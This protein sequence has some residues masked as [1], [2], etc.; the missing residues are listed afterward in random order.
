MKSKDSFRSK[1]RNSGE[2][3]DPQ[4][5]IEK[6]CEQLRQALQRG[7]TKPIEHILTQSPEHLRDQVLEELVA[8]ETQLRSKRGEAPT[9]EE[10]AARFGDR[11][12]AAWRG[13]RHYD[14]AI[15]RPAELE[16]S[17]HELD[18][19][20]ARTTFGESQE[21][22]V[23]DR[24]GEYE[25]NDQ[26]GAGTFGRVFK[27]RHASTGELVAIKQL[28]SRW[29]QRPAI[30]EQF[31]AEAQRMMR[32]DH[33]GVVRVYQLVDSVDL[34]YFVQEY[35]EGGD[36]THQIRQGRLAPQ[37]ATELVIQI[38]DALAHIHSFK[39]Y[40]RDL[41]PANVLLDSQ[42]KAH[43]ADFGLALADSDRWDQSRRPT[44][45][46]LYMSPEQLHG[47]WH[48]LNPR[49]DIWSLGVIYY[50]LL[51]GERPFQ[52]KDFDELRR[53]I[54]SRVPPA[55]R[56][57]DQSIPQAINR[58]CMSCLEKQ[59]RLR[60]ASAA[61]LR[62]DLRRELD[63][64]GQPAETAR[65]SAAPSVDVY[66]TPKLR[67]FTAAQADIYLRLMP[68]SY[69]NPEE[70][71][72]LIDYW[73]QRI[74]NHDPDMSF[75][76][77]VLVGVS[78]CGKSS[79]LEA[80]LLPRLPDNVTAILIQGSESETEVQLRKSLQKAFPDA[81]P[82]SSSWS[83]PEWTHRLREGELLR[84]GQK[85]LLVLDQ[86][87]QWLHAHGAD[88]VSLLRD[89]LQQCD[90]P[91]L[92]AI[93]CVREGFHSSLM[94]FVD[95]LDV[96]LDVERNYVTAHR[97]D[98]GH[99]RFVL[100]QFGC[101]LGRL[102][103]KLTPEQEKF[104]ET[105]V[106]QLAQADQDGVRSVRLVVLALVMA[107]REWTVAELE[108]LGGLD[109]IG[110]QFLLDSFEGRTAPEQYRR[111]LPAAMRVLESLLPGEGLEIKDAQTYA[112]LLR[113][114][115]LPERE[116]GSLLE[117]LVRK[118]FL[119]TPV[120]PDI[121]PELDVQ[122][123]S[124]EQRYYQLT[125]D[126]LVPSVR[127]WI[128]F[129]EEQSPSGRARL[130]LRRLSGAWTADYENRRHLPSLPEYLQIRRHTEKNRWTDLQRRMMRV[131][132]RFYGVRF[133]LG[134]TGL[135]ALVAIGF[136]VRTNVAKQ[137]EATRIQGLVGGLVNAE[138]NQ[139]P[140]IAKELDA[141]PT[142][143]A[144]YLSSLL[145]GNPST[146]DVKRSQLHARLA[147]V[148]RDPS[149]V[150]PLKE[151]LLTGKLTYVMPIR[152]QL[153]PYAATLTEEFRVVLREENDPQ[154]R[155]RASLALADYVRE[156]DAAFWT[157]RDLQFVADQLVSANAVYQPQ[158]WE[159][160]APVDTRLVQ[161]LQQVFVDSGRPENERLAA[162]NAL[163]HFLPDDVTR[164]AELLTV[165]HA[166]P[167]PDHLRWF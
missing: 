133:S 126:F 20:D 158:L 162:A 109:G 160:L 135:V 28:K 27:A 36:L 9:W 23:P 154:R 65:P 34:P 146:P 70:L 92:Q 127:Q 12:E 93:I 45:T 143:A 2:P 153:R 26:L 82:E 24:L 132:T 100:E 44:G 114:S 145:S 117:I 119:V 47:R 139:V 96:R 88:P 150:E 91:H 142:V 78:G 35:V 99:A 81:G 40:H 125:H 113:V 33:P 98:I 48:L 140:E 5:L 29:A 50:E 141:N 97:F 136:V 3:I 131:A 52:R 104:L 118:L 122:V 16:L 138:P 8:V 111:L 54:S 60:P 21:P 38:A 163:V 115:E 30:I 159:L 110:R 147:T 89:A 13:F 25:I 148:A 116:F 64:L 103:G 69:A 167:V 152:Q 59:V 156:A 155:F 77:G 53:E 137:Q 58:I 87:E 7:E 55:P 4:A 11:L 41:K 112:Q 37:E 102:E 79:L 18:E 71:P 22:T 19:T 166:G 165:A 80:G 134:T 63:Q 151:E 10:Y 144:T 105:A 128:E 90:G 149:L 121:G 15:S 123:A 124:D 49:C 46:Y 130:L 6:L 68:R 164:L 120:D 14:P 85:V 56:D 106:E 107:H 66:P 86:F 67:R 74:G 84:P 157:Q 57:L 94:R 73:K 43:L 51:T 39:L 76:I 83:L 161:P 72:E 1:E 61:D 31:L 129:K 101:G 75:R 17:T 95:S 32:F 108:Q 42:G 62:D